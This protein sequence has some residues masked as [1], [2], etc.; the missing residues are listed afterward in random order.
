[1]DAKKTSGLQYWQ[2]IVILFCL[3]W[4][5]I[6]IYRS[7]LPPVYGE[8][9][10][11]FGV[12]SDV[13]M[14]AI[15]SLYFLPYAALQIPAGLLMDRFGAKAVLVPSFALFAVAALIIGSATSL[16][17]V[18]LGSFC[19]GIG[20]SAFYSGAYAISGKTVPVSRRTFATAIINSGTGIGMAIGLIGSSWLV[21][22]LELPWNASLYACAGVI[23]FTMACFAWFIR[24]ETRETGG[25]GKGAAETEPEDP[26]AK[27]T[28]FS[29]RSFSSYL[30]NFANSYAYYMLVAWLPNF[31]ETERGF[32]GVAIGMAA[33]L[34][35]IAAIPGALF[36]SRLADRFHAK[37]LELLIFLEICSILTL[38]LVVAAPTPGLL[39]LGL[40]L[41][42]FS[43]K[44]AADALMVAHVIEGA[45]RERLSTYLA[46]FNFFAMSSSVAAPLVTGLISDAFH[47]KAGGFYVCVCLLAVGTVVFLLVNRRRG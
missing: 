27:T 11:A 24:P 2:T 41:Y 34:V 17:M 5:A 6:W 47:S 42:G 10:A 26:A 46:T 38:L 16:T 31:L 30:L 20:S 37:R 21:K 22:S 3:G 14:G 35:G 19:A 45:S 32:Q 1:M 33:A 9:Q 28:L 44:L 13:G 8:I 7:A 39:L 29:L 12:S 40:I 15:A 25:N 4:L 36:F 18:Y 23:L 43:G